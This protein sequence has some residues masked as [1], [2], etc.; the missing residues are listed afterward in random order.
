[1]IALEIG[2]GVG[3][4]L[5][6]VSLRRSP[7]LATLSAAAGLLWFAGDLV[8]PLL[9]AHR[10]PVTH[11]LLLYPLRAFRS[12]LRLWT[13]SAV[14]AASLV[15]P[16][17][18][19]GVVTA[20]LFLAVMV[21]AVVDRPPA[22]TAERRSIDIAGVGAVVVWGLLAGAAL[23]R[24]AGAR[25]DQTFL[26]AYEIGLL[27]AVAMVVI[28]DQYR[29][30]RAAIVTNLA[31][32]LGATGARSL[33][34]VIAEAL[35]DASVV[36]G[37][38]S[39][40]GFTDETG[41]PVVVHA[42]PG[43]VV[44]DLL[45]GEQRIA[46]LLHDA[47]LL[48]D[49]SL[50]DSVAALAAVALSNMRLQ[51]AVTVN[52]A[53]VAASRQRLLAV[54]DSERD[55]LEARVQDG[56]LSRLARVE[57]LLAPLGSADLCRQLESTRDTT[58][59]FARGVYPRPLDDVGLAA[60]SDLDL[61]GGRVEITVPGQRFPRDVEAAAYFLCAEALTN[62]AKYAKATSTSV[63]ITASPGTLVIDVTDNGSG[64][65]DPEKGTGLLG[66][67]DRLDVLGGVLEVQSSRHGTRIRGTI[68]VRRSEMVGR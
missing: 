62:V 14:W 28:D 65:A 25:L 27:A 18:Q 24:G 12:R 52:I 13:V 23:A 53:E 41:R 26:V 50:L 38:H 21:I 42:A 7:K 22:R 40:N 10:A 45:E 34:D 44:T 37:L 64:G 5:A 2:V 33:R 31:V 35:G 46:V 60:I 16:I 4:L 15:Y 36:I 54:A 39:P 63:V 3:Y 61:V 57:T 6:A 9:F 68:P 32:D 43:Q 17:G 58:S 51:Q 11:L 29:R 1:M 56:V 55:R 59:T 67:Q 8:G 49:R 66:L 19:H 20:A 47:S 48:R 30:S